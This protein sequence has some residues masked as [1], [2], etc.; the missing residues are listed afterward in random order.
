MNDIFLYI[1]KVCILQ[2]VIYIFYWIALRSTTFHQLNRFY[3]LTGLLI[4]F[5]LPLIKITSP[6]LISPYQINHLLNGFDE[7]IFWDNYPGEGMSGKTETRMD[8][9][10]LILL[11]Y[12][13]ISLVLLIR[14]LNGIFNIIRL[15]NNSMADNLNGI[16][17]FTGKHIKQPFSFL[18]WIFIPDKLKYSNTKITIL[19]HEKAHAHQG[20]SFDLL[21]VEFILIVLWFNPFV[22][23][24]RQSLKQV[25]EYLADSKA[26]ESKE[27]KADYLQSIV[28]QARISTLTGIASQFYWLTLKKR[29]QMITKNKTVKLYRLNYLMIIPMLVLTTLIF[30]NFSLIEPETIN[31]TGNIPSIK[32]IHDGEFR[33]TSGYGMRKHPITK[34]M[35][36]H[37]GVDFAADE[38]TPVHATADGMVLKSEFMKQGY[39]KYI[40]IQHDQ[41]YSTLYAQLSE[42]KVHPGDMVKKGDIIGL[43]GSSGL[44]TGSHLHYEVW[45]NG[46]KVN[47]EDYFK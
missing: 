44:S 43:V 26:I 40:V 14:S 42:F 1:I 9:T 25:H 20:H 34:E 10:M 27:V 5:I 29:I 12:C 19:K 15:R 24:F 46:E 38:G 30:S 17:F 22:F 16:I 37:N 36:M 47:P 33:I 31:K 41:V 23:L 28:S 11:I 32:P 6:A 2:S 7:T 45:K 13:S 39:G 21:F 35:K 18:N 4:S 8:L 3:L